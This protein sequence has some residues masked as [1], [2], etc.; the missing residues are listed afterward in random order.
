MIAQGLVTGENVVLLGT[1][2]CL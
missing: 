2:T 1:F